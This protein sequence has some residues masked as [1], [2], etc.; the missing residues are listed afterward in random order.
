MSLFQLGGHW[1]CRSKLGRM[2][3]EITG[4]GKG[5]KWGAESKIHQTH[6]LS[7]ASQPTPAPILPFHLPL[8]S[9]F[10]WSLEIQSFPFLPVLSA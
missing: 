4:V 10:R 6:E 9:L 3:P 8:L 1:E 7:E 5:G 2:F